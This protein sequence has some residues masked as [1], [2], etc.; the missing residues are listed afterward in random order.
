M[1]SHMYS[2]LLKR[3]TKIARVLTGFVV[4]WLAR[5]NRGIPKSIPKN[6]TENSTALASVS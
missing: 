3:I 2:Q 1:A 6:S 4:S 5:Y